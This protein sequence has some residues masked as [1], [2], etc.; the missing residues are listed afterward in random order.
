MVV[1]ECFGGRA[2]GFLDAGDLGQNVGA[3]PFVLCHTLE[4]TNL[5]LDSP[6][7][8]KNR[9]LDLRIHSHRMSSFAGYRTTR[10]G[11]RCG[12]RRFGG[13]DH[14]AFPYVA[15]RRRRLLVTTLTEL[16]AIA[17]AAIVGVRRIPNT[18]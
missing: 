2:Q 15:R 13:F 16:T 6:E 10:T 17:V 14:S 18:G 12:L 5:S 1:E 9:P 3:V 4:A 7:T 11:G 8:V